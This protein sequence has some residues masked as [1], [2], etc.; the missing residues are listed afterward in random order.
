MTSCKDVTRKIAS[1]DFR[2]AG[3]RG[4]LAVR[5]HLFLCRHCRCYAA[6]LRVIG[7]AAKELCGPCS[8]DPSTLERLERQILER[9]RPGTEDP[10]E[11]GEKQLG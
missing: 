11:T 7:A 8:Q 9:S 4:R 3:W 6:Q 10:N 5:L 2:E 1:D